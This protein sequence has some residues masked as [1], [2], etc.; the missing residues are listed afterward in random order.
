MAKREPGSFAWWNGLRVEVLGGSY[1]GTR[2]RYADAADET[3]PIVSASDLYDTEAAC[4]IAHAERL[5]RDA[6]ICIL[7]AREARKKAAGAAARDLASSAVESGFAG[8]ADEV[9]KIMG[10]VSD[11]E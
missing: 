8:F 11:G 6:E 2:I 5:E 9:K 4:Y 10:E 7:R 3:R 1:G